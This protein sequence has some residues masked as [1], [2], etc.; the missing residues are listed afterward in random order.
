MERYAQKATA[1]II[2]ILFI[3]VL[4][5]CSSPGTQPQRSPQDTVQS[6]TS[7]DG[8][9]NESAVSQTPEIE[10]IEV[11]GISV[12]LTS[13]EVVKGT[14]F[15]PNVIIQPTDATDKSYKLFSSDEFVLQP[16][17]EFGER[18]IAVG[19]GTAKLTVTAANGIT[20]TVTMTVTVP[21]ESISFRSEITINV[22]ESAWLR[23][24]V[25][26]VDATDKQIS[27]ES[28]DESI[29]TVTRNGT[30]RAVGAGTTVIQITAGGV[31]ADC[32]VT[33]VL[34]VIGIT[35]RTDRRAYSVG[36]QGSI[37]VQITPQD[38]TDQTYEVTI[39][40]EAATQT[41][42]NTFSCDATGQATIVV[43]A[44]NGIT[45]RQVIN[46]VDLVQFADEVFRL[47]NV[48]RANAGLPAFTTMP[49]LTQVAV[50]RANEAIQLFSH[51]RPDGRDCF[52]A[53][54]ELNVAY[55]RA[56]ENIAM[57]QRSPAEVV[58]GWMNSPG[59]RTN[60]LN[61]GFGRL[62][63]GVAMDNDGTL[64]WAQNFMD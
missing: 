61:R 23:T 52:T 18:W 20:A 41:G 32:T 13:H 21:V 3:A 25:A 5:A 6:T 36:S 17:G 30:I 22:G 15:S 10:T 38:A 50:V 29:A 26:P 39:I 14:V 49:S 35:V 44:S 34:P 28:G 4:I 48:E 54:T 9:G 12:E 45:G 62:G 58:R 43:T 57:G 11:S 7:S 1:V 37:S 51:D 60:I 27:F 42:E 40:G 64:Y 56:G 55:I 33:V 53:Y 47:T 19:G 46:V 16:L 63:I 8:H 24:E 2:L 59:H 31:S